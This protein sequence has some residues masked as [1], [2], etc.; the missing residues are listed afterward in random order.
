MG[1]MSRTN[2]RHR[3]VFAIVWQ[4]SCVVFETV[5]GVGGRGW[6]MAAAETGGVAMGRRI[7]ASIARKRALA[8]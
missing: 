1:K 4:V 2:R 8:S 5:A 7:E 6:G 3:R